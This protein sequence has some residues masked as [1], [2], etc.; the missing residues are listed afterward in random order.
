MFAAINPDWMMLAG[1]ALATSVFVRMAIRR[2][3]AGRV[4]AKGRNAAD[5]IQRLARP[6]H[7]WDGAHR[8]PGALVERQKVELQETA[9]EA[10]GQL[11]TKIAVLERLVATSSDQI[12]QMQRL[13]DELHAARAEAESDRA[14]A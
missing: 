1:I 6:K 8:D 9:R 10:Q 14:T 2:Q 5:P 11:A 3:R 4:V 13:L 12:K 7:A